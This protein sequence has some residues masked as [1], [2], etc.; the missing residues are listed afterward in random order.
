MERDAT[1]F[2]V[3]I[4]RPKGAPESAEDLAGMVAPLIAQSPT[5]LAAKLDEGLVAV[6]RLALDE[7]NEFADV[8][9]SLGV[10]ADLV[11]FNGTEWI[12][13][14][15]ASSA[16]RVDAPPGITST[17]GFSGAGTKPFNARAVRA[18]VETQVQS[19]EVAPMALADLDSLLP[20][21][22][23][24]GEITDYLSQT[25]NFDGAA[26]RRNLERAAEEGAAPPPPPPGA[27]QAE[28]QGYL[29]Q[30][31][32]FDGDA[33]RQRLED[34]AA[35]A[36][37]APP[38]RA[39]PL[40]EIE[41]TSALES[42]LIE[43]PHRASPH[44]ASRAGDSGVYMIKRE[45]RPQG[46]YYSISRKQKQDSDGIVEKPFEAV[47]APPRHA[48]PVSAPPRHSA[49]VSAPPR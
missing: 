4:R 13:L 41:R 18:M 42:P 20:K 46:G 47:S 33:V 8:F 27:S 10:T 32:T 39:S 30:T 2:G 5:Q 34:E 36:G 22:P 29:S 26:L 16:P 12:T 28:I 31:L 1:R 19:G 35:K 21:Q 9:V 23:S 15:S 14:R 38:R 37:G 48:A 44:S 11:E 25:L 49:P 3:R 17:V 24:V 40:S 6:K 43:Q 7:A 45:K